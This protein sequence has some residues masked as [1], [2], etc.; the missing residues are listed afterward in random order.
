MCWCAP[1][2]SLVEHFYVLHFDSDSCFADFQLKMFS[3]TLYWFLYLNENDICYTFQIR[4]T[5]CTTAGI[6]FRVNPKHLVTSTVMWGCFCYFYF[7]WTWT[8]LLSNI[9]HPFSLHVHIMTLY[10]GSHLS[11][12]NHNVWFTCS[13]GDNCS[14]LYKGRKKAKSN[15]WQGITLHQNLHSVR[16][17]V[18]WHSLIYPLEQVSMH[19]IQHLIYKIPLWKDKCVAN[20]MDSLWYREWTFLP[21][22]DFYITNN[23]KASL[24][25]CSIVLESNMK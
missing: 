9:Y 3:T 18:M 1:P 22:T 16:Q 4:C 10:A 21:N 23:T 20:K 13:P 14:D 12:V 7:K 2:M 5:R 24:T 6:L 8:D 25:W 19:L 17:E 11:V 15:I